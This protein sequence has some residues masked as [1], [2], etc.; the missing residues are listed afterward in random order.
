MDQLRKLILWIVWAQVISYRSFSPRNSRSLVHIP[1]S[2][3]HPTALHVQVS[4][5]PAVS[6]LNIST[7]VTVV[8]SEALSPP[9]KSNG[10]PL[11]KFNSLILSLTSTLRL[12]LY[13]LVNQPPA[14]NSLSNARKGKSAL[15]EKWRANVMKKLSSRRFWLQTVFLGLSLCF[16]REVTIVLRSMVTEISFSNFLNLLSQSPQ[17][18]KNLKITP[19]TYIYLVD[20]RPCISRAV[21]VS[22][23][24]LDRLVASGVDFSAAASGLN[25]LGR[26]P[27]LPDT[28]IYHLV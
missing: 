11:K 13:K 5:V 12:F 19:T 10:G 1:R 9:Q 16:V 18:I 27:M 26:S 8:D 3:S 2:I 14:V 7:N 17:K 22:P 20:G 4:K 6:S 25:I 24:M 21:P 23:A 28:S 15:G